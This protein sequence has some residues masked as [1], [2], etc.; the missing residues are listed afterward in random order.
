MIDDEDALVHA[1]LVQL[2]G[3]DLLDAESDT[4]LAYHCD[5]SSINKKNINTHLVKERSKKNVMMNHS[6]ARFDRF[7]GILDLKYASVWRELSSR[8]V[9]LCTNN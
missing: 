5:H 1:G 7:V 9:I 2:G 3:D 8:Q 6:P 4:I